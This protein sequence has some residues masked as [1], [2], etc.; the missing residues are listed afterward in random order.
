MRTLGMRRRT[1]LC[2]SALALALA[3]CG[4]EEGSGPDDLESGV[5]PG[6]TAGLDETGGD[7][8][9][10]GDPVLDVGS[11]MTSASTTGGDEQGDGCQAVDF[12]FVIDSSG[13]MADEQQHLINAFD[14]FISGIQDQLAQQSYHVGVISTD[15]YFGNELGCQQVGALVTQTAG[16]DSSASTCPFP[17]NRRFATEADDLSSLFACAGQLGTD[18]SGDERPID[19]ISAALSPG[20]NAPGACNEGFLRDDALLVIVLITDE[21][22]DHEGVECGGFFPGSPG[23]AGEPADW[24]QTILAAKGGQPEAIVP[25]SLIGPPGPQP[26]MCPGLDKCADGIVGAE[27]AH[28]LNQ[29]T[30]MFDTGVVGRVCESSYDQFFYDAISHVADACENFNPVD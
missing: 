11:G 13:S 10:S 12:L 6:W 25:L 28:R 24:Y 9:G 29:L 1:L 2:T 22:D 23:S 18:G 19:A 26:A 8:Q 7:S 5:N 27:P 3:A 21:E 20:M 14:G 17:A 30:S 16:A 4:A 15:A